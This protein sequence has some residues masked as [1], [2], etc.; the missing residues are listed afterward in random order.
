M[1]CGM[2]YAHTPREC[3][4]E[5]QFLNKHLE[6]VARRAADFADA[7]GQST[8]GKY[9]GLLHDLGKASPEFQNHLKQCHIAVQLGEK[10]PRSKVDHKLA[11]AY[12]AAQSNGPGGF[13]AIPLAGHHGG[14]PRPSDI[15]SK[16]SDPDV[17]QKITSVLDN[18]LPL[19]ADSLSSP[20]ILPD[21]KNPLRLE[22]F[23]RMIFSCLVDADYLDTEQH[24][25]PVKAA[26]RNPGMSIVDLWKRF[27]SQQNDMMTQAKDTPINR[28][29]R[30]VYEACI[31]AA[32]HEPGV[33]RLTV[34]TGG[35]KT[36][37]GMAFAL[38][39]A[40]Q[41]SL[42]RVV[43]AIPYT[44]IIDQNA[45]IYR[46]I[47]G[48][49]N[50]LEHHSAIEP[51]EDDGSEECP[52]A[53]LAAENW[54]M[55]VVVTTTVQ[56]FESLFSNKPSKCRKLHNLAR[57]VIVLDE[58]QT[59]PVELLQPIL[60]MLKDLVEHYGVSLV[61]ST[62]TQ[63]AFGKDSPYI[64]GF[65]DMQEIV[66]DPNRYF[67]LLRRVKYRIEQQPWPW[68]MVAKEIHDRDQVLCVVNS[69]KDALQLFKLLDDP[70]A[71][72]LSTLMCQA[73]RR[74]VLDEI[75][76]R[77]K[78]GNPCKVVSTQLVEA[79]VDLNFPCV[80]RALGPLDRIVQAAGRCNRE[81]LMDHPGEVIVF[82]PEDGR[83]PQ[84]NYST[85]IADAELVLKRQNCD[86]NDPRIFER[87]FTML[88]QDCNLDAYKIEHS[89]S[90]IN[91]PVVANNFKMIKN[92]MTG[93]VVPYDI[94]EVQPIL[95]T[96]K[97]K[98]SISGKG[99]RALQPYIVNIYSNDFLS[100]SRQGLIEQITD[101][102]YLWRGYY[103]KHGISDDVP[104]PTD[105]IVG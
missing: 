101:G 83:A 51:S 77:L 22:M 15:A 58:V 88:W 94:D 28:I 74:M 57:S 31:T 80:M 49:E 63:P 65:P 1:K 14:M 55:P 72:H 73:H 26:L 75:R 34:P 16:L 59:L 13:L 23:L 60:D 11:G 97:W 40:V 71:L 18:S 25:E 91:Y 84:G 32:E 104:D 7:F 8:A 45:Q 10:P 38:K 29:R 44:S 64:S 56:L 36:R 68:E 99:W 24:W 19:I 33:F 69:R 46:D 30:E 50:V 3:S 100:Y 89:R 85:A 81:G 48:A 95:D 96:I 67:D 52:K 76:K 87:Y 66:P 2:L 42:D 41:H 12:Y 70:N 5:W 21:I 17:I 82:M 98:G 35:G 43:V 103:G 9:I 105:L 6:D 39:H 102:L 61:L 54:D 78:N 20:S 90:R 62:A 53:R 93:I 37:S 79:G 92:G 27:E 4:D 47:L 86:L